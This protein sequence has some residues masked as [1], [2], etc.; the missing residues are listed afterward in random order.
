MRI[1]SFL[2]IL[3]ILSGVLFEVTMTKGELNNMT[4]IVEK[5]RTRLIIRC[6]D[7]GLCHGVNMAFRRVAEQGMVTAASVM[8]TTPW[9]D[10]AVEI[11]N[12]HPEISV[13]VHLTLNSEWKEYKWGP[14]LPYDQ[15]PTLVNEFG[16][17]Y[18]TRKEFM[19]HKPKVGEV[20][21]EIRAQLDF[22]LRKGLKISYIDNHM[23]TAISTLEFQQEMEK[24]AKEYRI[25]ISRYFGEIDIGN[26]YSFPPEQK[27]A[28]GLKL[29]DAMTTAGTYLLVCHIGTD[30]PEMQAMTDV[31]PFGLKNMS[32]HRQAEADMLCNAQFKQALQKKGIQLIGYNELIKEGLDTMKRPFTSDTYETVMQD[33]T[34]RPV[35]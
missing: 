25:G 32:V 8:V 20:A 27:L 19:A 10:E 13:G 14:I 2:L 35:K 34:I 30:T 21:K 16:K 6:D 15:V 7:I 18:S 26:V 12:Q 23:G 9:I 31:H 5:P 33:T 3:S 24:L 4:S 22:A 17:F 1:I 29:L 28:E 11:L